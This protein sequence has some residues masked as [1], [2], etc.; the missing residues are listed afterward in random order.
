MDEQ[1]SIEQW[2]NGTDWVKRKIVGENQSQYHLVL[3]K[4]HM[5]GLNIGIS[6]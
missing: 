1:M 6:F 4:Y 5:E 2:W 3:H